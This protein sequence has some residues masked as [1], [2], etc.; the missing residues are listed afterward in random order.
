[1]GDQLSSIGGRMGR[2]R[3]R[4][5]AAGATDKK[6]FT[7]S[8]QNAKTRGPTQRIRRTMGPNKNQARRN[9]V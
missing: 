3:N 9:K 4:Q 6:K 5:L 1:M 2:A 7:G 8:F